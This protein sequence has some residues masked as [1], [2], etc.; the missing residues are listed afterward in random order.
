MTTEPPTDDAQPRDL[1]AD[2]SVGPKPARGS[3]DYGAGD[4][5]H[6]ER[7]RARPRAAEHVHRRYHACAA[8]IIWC[9]KS[10]TTRST[11]RWPTMPKASA[12]RSTP[13]A[14]CTVEDD[15]RGIPV[16]LHPDLGVSTLEG[17]MTVL[18]FGG[19]FSKSAY[20]T[21][22]RSCTAWASRL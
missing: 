3:E 22:G 17:V 4:L 13:T 16:E 9:M 8:C 1:P 18:K 6:L 20:Q 14:R 2:G 12:S 7:S 21:L 11:R 19:K 10:S 15:G 5:E